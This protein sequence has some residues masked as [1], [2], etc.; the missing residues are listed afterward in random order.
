MTVELS[1]KREVKCET[2]SLVSEKSLERKMPLPTFDAFV[3]RIP[4]TQKE[5]FCHLLF[6][7][8]MGSVC[9][10]GLVCKLSVARKMSV[11]C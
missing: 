9:K 3:S 10:I 2:A 1:V 7:S 5:E 8:P 6:P 4:P 11:A